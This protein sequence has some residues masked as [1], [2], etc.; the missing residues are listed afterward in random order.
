MYLLYCDETNL[1]EKDNDFFVYGGIVVNGE[2]ALPLS[3]EIDSLRSDARVPPDFILK[4]NPGPPNLTHEEFIALKQGVINAAVKHDC[5][6]FT[7]LILHNLATSPNDARRN[8]INRVCYNF[9]L[10]LKK[11]DS[12]G[13]VLIDRFE[14]G[15]IDS[16]LREKFA[17]GLTGLPHCE[18][19]RLDRIVGFHYSAIGQSHFGSIV[20]IVLGSFRFAINAFTRQQEEYLQ[21]AHRLLELLSPLFPRTDRGSVSEWHLFFSPKIIKAPSFRRRYENL[22]A[23]LTEHGIERDQVITSERTY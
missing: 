8:E 15:I 3:R 13:L 21:T 9:N 4:F 18:R 10:L 23:F 22:K 2:S 11:L 16:H 12:P 6:L 17:I 14:D 20:D 7:S 19:L 5:I 1:E